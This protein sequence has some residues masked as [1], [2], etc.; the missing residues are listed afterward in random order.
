MAAGIILMVI[1]LATP[2]GLVQR[3]YAQTDTEWSEPINLSNSGASSDPS[4]VID[5]SGVIHVI[6][7]DAVDGYKY[8]NSKDGVNWSVPVTIDFPFDPILDTRPTLIADASGTIH[9][10]WTH[11][12]DEL[13]EDE[14]SEFMYG[15]ASSIFFSQ[16]INWAKVEVL[17]SGVLDF[18]VIADSRSVIHLAYVGSLA[19]EDGPAGIFYRRLESIT[20]APPVSLY[21]SQYF[22]TLALEDSHVRLAV[23]GGGRLGNVYAVWDDRPAKRIFLARSVDGGFNWLKS[24]Q[25]R[26]PEDATG[27]ALPY[28]VNVST[29]G[30]NVLLTWLLGQP[31]TLCSQY[32]QWSMDGAETLTDPVQVSD[33]LI[34]CPSNG[35]FV[36]KPPGY[37]LMKLELFGDLS[38]I[39]WNGTN[40]SSLQPQTELTALINPLTLDS[41]VLGCRQITSDTDTIYMV[42]CDQTGTND[43]WF[44]SR[45]FGSLRDWFPTSTWA[46]ST[47][48][49]FIDQEISSIASVSGENGNFH[50]MWA[51]YSSDVDGSITSK[52]QYAYWNAG[53]WSSPTNIINGVEG[54]PNYLTATTNKHGDV[55]LAWVQ[56]VNGDIYFN[57]ANGDKAYD[58]SEW[59]P[60]LL[61]PSLSELNTTPDLLTDSSNGIAI[62]YSIPFNENRGIYMVK[63]EDNGRTWSQPVRI[64]DAI[65]A[66]WDSV[67][68]PKIELSQ[69]GR[70]HLLVTRK[71]LR[72]GG[73][74]D[75]V[76]YLQSVDGGTTWTKPELISERSV[77]WSEIVYE[78]DNV[79]Y[80]LWQERIGNTFEV[81]SEVSIDGGGS[82]SGAL[83]VSSVKDGPAV[84]ALARDA[85]GQMYL[86]QSHLAGMRLVTEEIHWD[87]SGWTTQEAKTTILSQNV[88]RYFIT[89]GIT[90]NRVLHFLVSIDYE[91]LAESAVNDIPGF[92]RTLDPLESLA[93][94]VP[95]FIPS[96][97]ESFM[98]L[99]P[100]PDITPTQDSSLGG[101]EDPSNA[102]MRNLVGLALVAGIVILTLIFLRPAARKKQ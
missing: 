79:L 51:Q 32:S 94:Q 98:T 42:G 23:T 67:I 61:I 48:I 64:F 16:P 57:W 63:S 26:G 24:I 101:F 71:S 83:K 78:G 14:T 50:L 58:A 20:W 85:N 38:F 41:V 39:A 25:L 89:S 100:D 21:S 74:Q 49:S 72:E 4:I 55:L 35:M 90:T 95:L 88:D 40:W 84:I 77:Q 31:G 97:A 45:K 10:F 27:L 60:A 46:E 81:F 5:S 15:R 18:D 2:L 54:I 1:F 9:I 92:S 33:E 52:L 29:T 28:D 86:M 102:N 75:S 82:W 66:N 11:L 12:D 68:S 36:G 43:I 93:T 13:D 53:G 22:R 34:T 73:Q 44:R 65:E 70:L 6:W 3:G 96:P 69:G 37:F 99:V 56:G 76:Y 62:I 59:S 7:V 87:G 47:A 91:D 19:T 17:A 8:V 30:K 80:R